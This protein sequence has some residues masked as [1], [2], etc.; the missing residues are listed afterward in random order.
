MHY[1]A[2]PVANM[3]GCNRSLKVTLC[4]AYRKMCMLILQPRPEDNIHLAEISLNASIDEIKAVETNAVTEL[5]KLVQQ[6]K[7]LDPKNSAPLYMKCCGAV[8]CC[9]EPSRVP[10][11]NA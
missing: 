5:Q 10:A 4:D 9:G 6:V 2:L 8:V 11:K 7:L 1:M 3:P